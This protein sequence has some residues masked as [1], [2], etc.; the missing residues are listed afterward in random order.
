MNQE[1]S[2]C[3]WGSHAII[4][5]CLAQEIIEAGE[6]SDNRQRRRR[7]RRKM[8]NEWSQTGKLRVCVAFLVFALFF[9]L[10]AGLVQVLEKTR[11][12]RSPHGIVRCCHDYAASTV[13]GCSCRFWARVWTA[14]CL[15]CSSSGKDTSAGVVQYVCLIDRA[16]KQSSFR[17]V[18]LS[19]FRL[20]VQK[21]PSSQ[22]ESESGEHLHHHFSVSREA[23]NNFKQEDTTSRKTRFNWRL[24]LSDQLIIKR[25]YWRLGLLWVL[26][27]K[28]VLF[29]KT[30]TSLTPDKLWITY[31][32]RRSC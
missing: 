25:L 5:E 3:L 15:A 20:S 10:R 24:L 31:D 2:W 30:D 32:R 1:I 27:R 4:I 11:G 17:S 28:V 22:C 13:K 21:P 19:I 29:V 23:D 26:Q 8:Y 18:S 9:S 14:S 7:R 12:G 16:K 6:A